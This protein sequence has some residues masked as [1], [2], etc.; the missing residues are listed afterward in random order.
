MQ[1][2]IPVSIQIFHALDIGLHIEAQFQ[3]LLGIA[4]QSVPRIYV[5]LYAEPT[6]FDLKG[7]FNE[8]RHSKNIFWTSG[9]GLFYAS[10]LRNRSI[11]D[12][13]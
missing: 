7:F 5:G 6:P 12:A 4:Y 2:A 9:M 10:R 1:Q 3:E 11:N 13:V 8:L